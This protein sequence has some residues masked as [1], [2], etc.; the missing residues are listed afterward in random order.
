MILSKKLLSCV[1]I[2][3]ISVSAMTPLMVDAKQVRSQAAKNNFK[4]SHPCPSNGNRRGS[5]PGY[6]IDHIIALAC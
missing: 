2:G 1:G 4:A 5:C 3:L 6:I